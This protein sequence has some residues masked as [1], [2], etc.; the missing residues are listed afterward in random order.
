MLR[1]RSECIQTTFG[2]C[3][4][5]VQTAALS[6]HT[7]R[8]HFR[9]MRV[10]NFLKKKPVRRCA[11]DTSYPLRFGAFVVAYQFYLYL[12]QQN[13]REAPFRFLALP[14]PKNSV[15]TELLL[16][17]RK[18]VSLELFVFQKVFFSHSILSLCIVGTP[19]YQARKAPSKQITLDYIRLH[20]PDF[21]P[22]FTPLG[23]FSSFDHCCLPSVTS[24]C[25]S[26]L[27]ARLVTIATLLAKATFTRPTL[28]A[29]N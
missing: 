5:Y 25:R 26:L 21:G 24:Y 6:Y 1:I 15:S 12:L 29:R 17:S 19:I 23:T 13:W 22:Q 14:Q 27:F 18:P 7:S 10:L 11:L 8:M 2:I 16:I 20:Q 9:G 28:F 4:E 3:S